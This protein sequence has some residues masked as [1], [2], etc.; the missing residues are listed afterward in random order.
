[1]YEGELLNG[2]ACGWGM[3]RDTYSTYEGHFVDDW[4][5]GRVVYKSC[6]ITDYREYRNNRL[7]GKST[8]YDY[9][10]PH[11]RVSQEDQ[12]EKVACT[13]RLYDNGT[14]VKSKVVSKI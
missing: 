14:K 9:N 13:N 5:Q 1:M 4:W 3:Y 12:V 6:G 8:Q 10:N 7:H 11:G 2:I